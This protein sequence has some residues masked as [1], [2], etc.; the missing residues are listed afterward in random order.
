MT[1]LFVQECAHGDTDDGAWSLFF[2]ESIRSGYKNEYVKVLRSWAT[3]TP[4][5]GIMKPEGH[6][7]ISSFLNSIP[8]MN[9]DTLFTP[10][11]ESQMGNIHDLKSHCPAIYFLLHSGAAIWNNDLLKLLRQMLQISRP[12]WV[13]NEECEPRMHPRSDTHQEPKKSKRKACPTLEQEHRNIPVS[14]PCPQ[15]SP[16]QESGNQRNVN[17]FRCPTTFED[18]I[19]VSTWQK[20]VPTCMYFKIWSLLYVTND[21]LQYIHRMVNISQIILLCGM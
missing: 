4:E 14:S 13:E 17:S 11:Q 9:E 20:L 2:P 21:L 12:E 16:L 6:A 3:Q 19:W 18:F 1:L 8:Q 10:E 15:M 7:S 5:V